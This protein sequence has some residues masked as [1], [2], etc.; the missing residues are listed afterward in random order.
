[1]VIRPHKEYESLGKCAE[2]PLAGYENA[3]IERS[4]SVGYGHDID[5][6][7]IPHDRL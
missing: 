7:W 4:N 5:I 2:S 6:P 3:R 1:M